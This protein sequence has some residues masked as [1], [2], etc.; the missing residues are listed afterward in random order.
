MF[1]FSAGCRVPFGF[2]SLRRARSIFYDWRAG[3]GCRVLRGIVSNL[4]RRWKPEFTVFYYHH[5]ERSQQQAQGNEH[6]AALPVLGCRIYCRVRWRVNWNAAF[7]PSFSIQQLFF[8]HRFSSSFSLA[9]FSLAKMSL[10]SKSLAN[11]SLANKRRQ[12]QQ[13]LFL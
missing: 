12:K 11:F 6:L 4:R 1:V 8:Q 3:R 10:A 9:S 2:C 7:H 5:H 13:I